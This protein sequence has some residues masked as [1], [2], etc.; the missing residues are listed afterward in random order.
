[1]S[2]EKWHSELFDIIVDFGKKNN[3][4]TDEMMEFMLRFS[5]IFI[6]ENADEED[7]RDLCRIHYKF[8]LEAVKLS[9]KEK[10][11]DRDIK[12]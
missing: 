7:L 8:T 12:L 6:N 2:H 9:K 1:M 3:I 11:N 10:K 4:Y 5:T